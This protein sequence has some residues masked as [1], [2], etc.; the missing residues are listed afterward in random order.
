MQCEICGKEFQTYNGVCPYCR[1][2]AEGSSA[3]RPAAPARPRS[4]DDGE[5]GGSPPGAAPVA[6]AEA[7]PPAR[8]ARPDYRRPSRHPTERTL[9]TL[10]VCGSVLL[11]V[12][13]A[14][15]AVASLPGL[16]PPTPMLG[17][18]PA[19]A[20]TD[21]SR[22]TIATVA[23][24]PT[25]ATAA[26]TRGADTSEPYSRD[27]DA[28]GR[29]APGHQ[30]TAGTRAPATATTTRGGGSIVGGVAPSPTDS[31]AGLNRTGGE[32][33]Y[34]GYFYPHL[35]TVEEQVRE[36]LASSLE[37]DWSE[38][39]NGLEELE[40]TTADGIS[41]VV[42]LPV[43]PDLS[44]AKNQSLE[45][46]DQLVPESDRYGAPADA[47]G[48]G[49]ETAAGSLIAAGAEEIL[50]ATGDLERIGEYLPKELAVPK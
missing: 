6:A 19:P 15:A 10:L 31:V 11:V 26:P 46:L 32:M 12:L 40:R 3:P 22:S 39:R 18:V 17:T 30:V 48:R 16:V 38:L 8:P 28:T 14:W 4:Q 37:D 1:A 21:S 27:P 45:I 35:S 36:M 24:R 34:V 7:P 33:R 41:R 50:R 29:I 2:K 5:L 42:S 25:V 49:D 9:K 13:V 47:H 44:D 20:A 43:S 23:T